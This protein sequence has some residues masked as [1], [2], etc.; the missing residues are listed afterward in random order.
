MLDS[1]EAA[2]P[3]L[4]SPELSRLW[5]RASVLERFSV[6]G[7]AGHLVRAGEGLLSYL[8]APEPEGSPVDAPAYFAE[9]LVHTDDLATTLPSIQSFR[10]RQWSS[11]FGTLWNVARMRGDRAI[12]VALSRREP[13]TI[14][15]LRVL[16]APPFSHRS[17]AE[18]FHRPTRR[19]RQNLWIPGKQHR[20]PCDGRCNSKRVGVRDGMFR[21]YGSRLQHALLSGELEVQSGS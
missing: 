4:A 3:V 2:C 8:S 18:V 6:R 19:R 12:L 5:E 20:I 17:L 11:P 16:E 15:A 21:L 9:V 13:E 10:N 14:D 1:H 7:L